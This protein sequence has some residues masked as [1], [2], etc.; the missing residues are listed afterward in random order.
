LLL[1]KDARGDVAAE[2]RRSPPRDGDVLARF[3]E[4]SAAVPGLVSVEPATG[5]PAPRWAGPVPA[6]GPA[7]LATAPFDRHLDL[8]WRRSSYSSITAPAHGPSPGA[9]VSTE[10]EEPGTTDEPGDPEPGQP[11]VAG[12]PPPAA[13]LR[14]APCVLAA[15]PA[16]AE[17][18]TFV[19][20]VLES[21]DFSAPDL[22]AEL[23]G[24]VGARMGAYPG[25]VDD[26]PV[27][28]QGLE[29][30]IL[31]PMGTLAGGARLADIDRRDRLDELGF[32]L[33]LVGG[34]EPVG[35]V[36]TDQMATLL[37]KYVPPGQPLAGYAATLA[38]PALA[39]R[40][41]GYLTGSLDL[42]FRLRGKGCEE[43]YF[44]VDYK[45][46]WLGPPGEALSAWHYRPAALEAEMCR[47][48]YVLQATFYLVALHRYLR[49]RLPAYDPSAHLGGALYL[50]LR[51][52]TG[53]VSA[54]QDD[55]PSGVF[56]WRPAVELVTSMSDLFA[57]PPAPGVAATRTGGP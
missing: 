28:V 13:R 6:G 35:E 56:A 36:S 14:A 50:F 16:G 46:N 10:P 23:A 5:G 54:A 11:A 34:D 45:T 24:A 2:G 25:S 47:S 43:R 32:E 33:P 31:T 38:G 8:R 55:Q 15:V 53:P 52:M 17:V 9:L 48:H 41:R 49:W 44:V 21:A 7:E 39:T 4:I 57:G 12:P 26:V 1:A 42:V 40:L 51:G 19:H 22:R 20:N 27:L 30:A 3:K 18:G 29:A 37:A